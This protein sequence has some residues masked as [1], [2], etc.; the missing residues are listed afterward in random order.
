MTTI[1]FDTMEAVQRLRGSG[2]SEEQAKAV[3]QTVRDAVTGGV[4]TK[5]DIAGLKGEIGEIKT[6]LKWIKAIG[7]AMF[8]VC[9]TLLVA[10]AIAVIKLAF[11]P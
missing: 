7:G 11:F 4:A 2:M 5:A 6:E 10:I 3:T 1:P 9:I 8:S